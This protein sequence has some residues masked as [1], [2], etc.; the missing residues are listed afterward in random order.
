MSDWGAV[1]SWDYAL[2]GLDQESGVQFDA[3]MNGGEWFAEPLRKANA[4]CRL[5]K[6]R[7]SDMARRILRSVYATG[8]DKWGP[9]P[10]VD[11]AEHNEIALETARQGIV[12]LR[13]DGVLPLSADTTARIAV[14]GGHAQ[15]GVPTGT[16]SSAVAP[17]GGYAAV[18][19][20]GGPGITGPGRNL[21]LLPSSPFEE[22]K[23]LMPKAQIEF[24][25]GQ[26]PAEAV[27]L[28]QQS[29]VAIVSGIRVEGEGFDLLDLSLP[30]GQD[31]VIE[32]VAAANPNTIVITGN[33]QP[34]RHAVARQGEGDRRSLVSRSGRRPRDRR[35]A[36]R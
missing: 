32:A 28:V 34:C 30:W 8:F 6:E 21:R 29:D 14:I 19:K 15:E 27:L 33:R 36:L 7:L 22:L 26:S 4:E 3:K 17:V 31:A 10:N 24:D 35:S 13:N 9:A 1:H 25:P 23:K 12:L 20:I 18:I 5:P 16:G 11:M 2:A